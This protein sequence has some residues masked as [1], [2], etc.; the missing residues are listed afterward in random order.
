MP[1]NVNHCNTV[2]YENKRE[3]NT[4]FAETGTDTD[5]PKGV[6]TG[7]WSSVLTEAVR[8]DPRLT[9]LLPHFNEPQS[10]NGYIL[11]NIM[12][13]AVIR[14]SVVLLFALPFCF[15]Q[16]PL[17][18]L[19]SS[20]RVATQKAEKTEVAVTGPARL[21]TVDD[22]NFERNVRQARTDHAQ[23]PSEMTPDGR[24]AEMEKIEA[25][26]RTPQP[27][28]IRGYSYS[29]TVRNDS[30]KTVKV[31]FWEY[32]FIEL[33]HTA[34]VVRRQFLCAV[35]LKKGRQI[36]LLAFSSLGPTEVISADSLAATKQKIFDEHVQVNR[37]EYSDDTV[38][39]RGNWK[40]ADFKPAIDRATATPWKKEMCRAF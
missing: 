23:D 24:R 15:A 28:D 40:F 30:D 5:P 4:S 31:V 18:V 11:P 26:A 16:D 20:W 17:P 32:R 10:P 21:L 12:M 35:D 7:Q 37:I 38:V 39:Q 8:P 3:V 19:G 29:A 34:N 1:S 33:A 9:R 25:Q 14:A 6:E 2:S 27:N 13:F 22:K 36:E